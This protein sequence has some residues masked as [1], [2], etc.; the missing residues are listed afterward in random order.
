MTEG[1]LRG[2]L[3]QQ[4]RTISGSALFVIHFLHLEETLY[5]WIESIYL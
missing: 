3:Q 2:V 5:G 1:A 4:Q